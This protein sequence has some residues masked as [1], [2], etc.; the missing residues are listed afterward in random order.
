MSLSALV[1]NIEPRPAAR[2]GL[3]RRP[4]KWSVAD[5]GLQLR[6]NEGSTASSTRPKVEQNLHP[7]DVEK[8]SV[9][10]GDGRAKITPD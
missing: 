1:M 6:R 10:G 2:V 7:H 4:S 3:L 8:L 5:R 9:S